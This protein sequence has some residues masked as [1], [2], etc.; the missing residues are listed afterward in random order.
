MTPWK[1]FWTSKKFKG[2]ILSHNVVIQYD[3]LEAVLDIHG[4]Q[5]SGS[6][7]EISQTMLMNDITDDD[8]DI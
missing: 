2:E 3:I 7:Q 1:L 8:L 4:I 5:R 6:R